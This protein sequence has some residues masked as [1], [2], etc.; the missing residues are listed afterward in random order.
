MIVIADSN[1]IISALISP[2]GSIASVLKDKSNIQFIAP[3]YLL[4]EVCEHWEKIVESTTLSKHGLFE[5]FYFYRSK[6]T[7][8]S[9]T[10]V[11]KKH[12]DD[13]AEIVK[14]IDIDDA[15][16]VSLHFY[17]KHKLWT[18]DKALINGLKAKGYDICVT[19][20]ELRQKLYK[21]KRAKQP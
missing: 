12:R 8:I 10:S 9:V 18:G 20:A 6:I 21:N 1:I 15:P 5:E 7:F 13:A 2:K 16:F 4:T 11:P 17:K 3:D 19:T 14:D